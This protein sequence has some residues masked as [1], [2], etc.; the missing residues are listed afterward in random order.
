M[1]I[2]KN[3]R[4]LG[5]ILRDARRKAG[6][7]ARDVGDAVGYSEEMWYKIEQGKRVPDNATVADISR[8]LGVPLTE[9]LSLLGISLAEYRGWQRSEML[10]MLR[11]Y[12]ETEDEDPESDPREELEKILK[13]LD[14]IK[15]GRK[16]GTVD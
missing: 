15:D 8:L 9:M 14:G 2:G 10:A 16:G 11:S 12:T 1:I 4:R 6:L 7:T 5:A 3:D 13:M